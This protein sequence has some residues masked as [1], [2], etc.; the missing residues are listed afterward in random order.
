MNSYGFFSAQL[1]FVASKTE[2]STPELEEMMDQLAI[3]ANQVDEAPKF[4]IEACFMRSA[5]RALAGVAGFL[6]Q[7]ILPEVIAAENAVGELQVRWTI[8]IS[9][10]LMSTMMTHAEMTNDQDDLELTLPEAPKMFTSIH[11]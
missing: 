10:S 6:Q 1:R 8:D 3:I 9:M 7:Q 11:E 4:K 5:A 2:R